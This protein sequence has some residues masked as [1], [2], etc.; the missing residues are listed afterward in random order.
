[1]GPAEQ[2]LDGDD[3]AGPQIELGLV[4]HHELTLVDCCAQ[5]VQEQQPV[6]AF[7]EVRLV[8]GEGSAGQLGPVHRDVRA[9][10]EAGRIGGI[11]GRQRDA[12][13]R[14]DVDPYRVKD[15]GFGQ[16]VRQS[17]GDRGGIVGVSVHEH[18]D[19]LVTPEPDRQVVLAQAG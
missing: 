3:L 1:M 12:D 19:K 9:P 5:F 13:A 16:P 11:S 2:A 14:A 10:Q 8:D 18:D 7:V 4:V 6:P 15:K 17:L